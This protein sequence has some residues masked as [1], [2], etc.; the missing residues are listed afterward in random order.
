MPR[1]IVYDSANVQQHYS[2]LAQRETGGQR[3]RLSG[4]TSRRLRDEAAQAASTG[5]PLAAA[6]PA[7][8]ADDQAPKDGYLAKIAKYV[9]AETITLVTV[10]FAAFTIKGG[11]VWVAVGVGALA[12]V[13]YLMSTSL[14]NAATTPPPRSYFYVLSVAA[15]ALWALAVIPVVQAEAGLTGSHLQARQ[16]FF[17]ALASFVIPALDTIL[18]WWTQKAS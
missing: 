12:N 10:F 2:A 9:P 11:W 4:R 17:L 1:T 14:I 5:A 7:T 16:T 18:T 15:F 6:K 3:R 13:V 8:A